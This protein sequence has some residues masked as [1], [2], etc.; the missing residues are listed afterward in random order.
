MATGGAAVTFCAV[1]R[2]DLAVG[3]PETAV[4]AE[5]HA[6]P[7]EG[8]ADLLPRA[9]DP[10]VPHHVPDRPG[11]PGVR[12]GPESDDRRPVCGLGQCCPVCLS[13]DLPIYGSHRSSSCPVAS[14]HL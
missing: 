10:S 13:L 5:Q 14:I 8:A 2:H 9:G 1:C 6:Q 11:V 4:G 3:V 12:V 7:Q